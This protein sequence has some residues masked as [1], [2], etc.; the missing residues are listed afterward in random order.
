MVVDNQ[1]F[2]LGAICGTTASLYEF[3]ADSSFIHNKV[4]HDERNARTSRTRPDGAQE[5]RDVKSRL[6]CT[7]NKLTRYRITLEQ[8]TFSIGEMGDT[9]NGFRFSDN[10][11]E[12]SVLS[13]PGAQG[14][15]KD[16]CFPSRDE[17]AQ[18]L[19]DWIYLQNRLAELNKLLS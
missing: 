12:F 11:D 4:N 5:R 16:L 3:K 2:S 9:M 19:K 7:K 14:F 1:C 13:V 18:A 17:L 8:T 10:S 6:A 15:E